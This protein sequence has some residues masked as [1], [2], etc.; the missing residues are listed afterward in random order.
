MNSPLLCEPSSCPSPHI[1]ILNFLG[2]LNN[3][4]YQSE[5]RILDPIY[6]GNARWN[7]I[8]QVCLQFKKKT[9]KQVNM[10]DPGYG[11]NFAHLLGWASPLFQWEGT[12]TYCYHLGDPLWNPKHSNPISRPLRLPLLCAWNVFSLAACFHFATPV[13][14]SFLAWLPC[15]AFTSSLN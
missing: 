8:K 9:N 7:N 1:S 4:C 10:R 5:A 2:L 11:T 15:K 6:L 13:T 12:V 14:Y 3:R